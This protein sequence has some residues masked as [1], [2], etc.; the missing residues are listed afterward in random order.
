MM[1]P[2][3]QAQVELAFDKD[4]ERLENRLRKEF[5]EEQK[6]ALKILF[7]AGVDFGME[8]GKKFSLPLT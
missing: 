3:F 7:L 5:S 1:H 6:N 2:L 8:K 4:I